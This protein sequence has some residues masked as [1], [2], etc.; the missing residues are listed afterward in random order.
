MSSAPRACRSAVKILSF[1][2]ILVNFWRGVAEISLII[3]QNFDI[4]L[5]FIDKNVT[6]DI[7]IDLK[8]TKEER[9]VASMSSQWG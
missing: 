4:K 7:E 2:K 8:Y 6:S 5:K 3:S 1:R 9:E